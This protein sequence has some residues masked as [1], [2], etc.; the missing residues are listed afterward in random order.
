MKQSGIPGS[1]NPESGRLKVRVYK[2]NYRVIPLGALSLQHDK[3]TP[4]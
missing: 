3:S 4:S 1:K 2:I